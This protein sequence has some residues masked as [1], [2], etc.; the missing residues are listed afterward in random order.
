MDIELR[1]TSDEIE[2]NYSKGISFDDCV[3]IIYNKIDKEAFL[4]ECK[5]LSSMYK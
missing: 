5:D 1:E 3:K 2:A 4:I